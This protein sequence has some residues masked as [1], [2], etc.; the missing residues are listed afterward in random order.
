MDFST[1]PVHAALEER[2]ARRTE[3]RRLESSLTI[4]DRCREAA[5]RRLWVRTFL[6]GGTT[7]TGTAL[8]TEDRLFTIECCSAAGSPRRTHVALDAVV[9]LTVAEGRSRPRT[10]SVSG[11][12]GTAMTRAVADLARQ[13]SDVTLTTRDGATFSGVPVSLGERAIGLAIGQHSAESDETFGGA[14]GWID[15]VDPAQIVSVTENAPPA[16]DAGYIR[17]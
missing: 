12:D 8:A 9:R 3:E 4:G 17:D 15:W 10:A 7:V 2:R 5:E 11:A 14:V 13:G 6:I 16:A 1:D